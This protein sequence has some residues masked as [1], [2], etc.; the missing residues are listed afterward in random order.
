VVLAI[1]LM[2]AGVA[3]TIGAKGFAEKLAKGLAGVVLILAVLPCLLRACSCLLPGAAPRL[4]SAL[5]DFLLLPVAG[6]LVVVGLIAWRRRAERAKAR[7]LWL[8][9][10]GAARGRALPA[11]PAQRDGVER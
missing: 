7:E 10:N 11:P 2:I 4:P 8:R 3:L 6:I 1:C 9:R 5:G